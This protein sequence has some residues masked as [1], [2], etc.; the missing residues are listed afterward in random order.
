[1]TTYAPNFTPRLKLRYLAGGIEHTIQVRAPRGTAFA[2]VEALG[3]DVRD[4]FLAIKAT[5]YADFAWISGE[6][7]LTDSDIF[8]PCTVPLGLVDNVAVVATSS[9]VQRISGLTFSGR[10]P[11]S[12]ARFT[13]YGSKI[14]D[15]A[16]GLAGSNGVIVTAELA[17]IGTIAA[18]ASANFV[19][20]SGAAAIFPGRGTYKPNDH[21]L[22]L[23]RKGT[24]A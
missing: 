9:A 1:M 18:I 17:G 5:I 10:A 16:A 19:A 3:P 6:V 22:K 21:L 14:L 12:R 2:A 24:I 15:D 4:C 20:G 23:V 13:M 7:A 11:G 8:L